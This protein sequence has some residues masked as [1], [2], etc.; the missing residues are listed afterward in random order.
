MQN[1]KT[2]KILVN[3]EGNIINIDPATF[4]SKKIRKYY[5]NILLKYLNK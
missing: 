4:R 5:E 2:L 1:I 3:S